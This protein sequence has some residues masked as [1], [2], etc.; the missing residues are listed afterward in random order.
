MKKHLQ[1]YKSETIEQLEQQT[2]QKKNIRKEKREK[3]Y[4][5]NSQASF[6]ANNYNTF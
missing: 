6:T 5:L 3:A 4:S 1:P 2:N